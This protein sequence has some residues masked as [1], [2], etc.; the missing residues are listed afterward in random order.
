MYKHSDNKHS[1]HYK[2]SHNKHKC[3]QALQ[4]FEYQTY[5]NLLKVLNL[6]IFVKEKQFV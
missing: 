1:V 4:Y 3:I 5:N 2:H 6:L